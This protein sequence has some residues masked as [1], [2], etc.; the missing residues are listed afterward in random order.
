MVL[1]DIE[2]I[3]HEG[4]K[5]SLLKIYFF[6]GEYVLQALRIYRDPTGYTIVVMSTYLRCKHYNIKLQ[7]MGGVVLCICD[8]FI[9][10]PKYASQPLS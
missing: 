6:F 3:V 10:L 8:H 2:V 5:L 7:V 1:I 4:F 9:T